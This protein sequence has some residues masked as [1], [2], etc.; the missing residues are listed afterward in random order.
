MNCQYS[1]RPTRDRQKVSLTSIDHAVPGSIKTLPVNDI[2]DRAQKYSHW[3]S[4]LNTFSAKEMTDLD[5]DK[6]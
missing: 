3:W 2:S 1:P 5:I 4:W 6:F